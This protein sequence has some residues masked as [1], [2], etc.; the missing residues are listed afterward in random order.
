MACGREGDPT[1]KREPCLFALV[2]VI[3]TPVPPGDFD[4]LIDQPLARRDALSEGVLV[5]LIRGPAALAAFCAASC[6]SW[7]N[8]FCWTEC[9]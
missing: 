7:T 3:L 1:A 9:R 5:F 6:Q 8:V 4:R 2:F